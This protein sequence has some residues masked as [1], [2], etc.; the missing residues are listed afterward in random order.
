M[1]QGFGRAEQD[2][3]IDVNYAKMSEFLVD[4]KRVS[5]DWRKRLNAL[6][7]PALV[8]SEYSEYLHCLLW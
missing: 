8:C 6:Q 7:A 4:R 5:A 1:G 3:P 2:V